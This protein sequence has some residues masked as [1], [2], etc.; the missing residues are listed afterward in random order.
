MLEQTLSPT[1]ERCWGV[2]VCARSQASSRGEA[3]DT[4]LLLSVVP[5]Y[6]IS[7]KFTEPITSVVDGDCVVLD[8]VVVLSKVFLKLSFASHDYK[9]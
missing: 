1:L 9:L 6:S 8:I 7:F 3:K 5:N 4:A 2:C